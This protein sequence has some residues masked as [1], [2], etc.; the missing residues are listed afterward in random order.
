MM[1]QQL[2]NALFHVSRLLSTPQ[3]VTDIL[4]EK[5]RGDAGIWTRG[6]LHAKQA[7]YRW[8]TSPMSEHLVLNVV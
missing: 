4:T 2:K 6:L 8:A 1:M 3:S 7:L 5:S